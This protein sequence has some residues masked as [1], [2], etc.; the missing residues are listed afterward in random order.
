MSTA[1]NIHLSLRL[2]AITSLAGTGRR[3]LDIGSDHAYVP[4]SLVK[5]GA[6]PSAIAADINANALD[7][8]RR[9][10]SEHDLSDRIECILSDGMDSIELPDNIDCIVISGMGGEL[11]GDIISRAADRLSPDARLIV[12]PQTKASFLRARLMQLRLFVEDERLIYDD[13]HYYT[14]MQLGR[15]SKLFDKAVSKYGADGFLTYGILPFCNE[16]QVLQAYMQDRKEHYE[17]IIRALSRQQSPDPKYMQELHRRLELTET[18]L[19]Q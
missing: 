6:Y 19:T 11:I 9:H 5:S 18:L 17:N 12:Q 4:I 13:R 1:H 14:I 10:I 2:L 16:M 7:I 3:V 15:S 8:S